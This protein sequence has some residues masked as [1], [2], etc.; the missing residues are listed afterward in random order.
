VKQGEKRKGDQNDDKSNN[1]MKNHSNEKN[2][3]K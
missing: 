3:N 2:K 1:I